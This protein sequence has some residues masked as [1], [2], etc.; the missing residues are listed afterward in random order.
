MFADSSSTPTA[1]VAETLNSVTNDAPMERLREI[2]RRHQVCCEV[3]PERS[4]LEGRRIQIGFELQLCGVNSHAAEVEGSSHPVP[5]CAQCL[6]TYQDIRQVAEWILPNKTQPTRY[7]IQA[8]DHSIH[9]APHKRKS[10]NEV[11]VTI[12]I[13]HRHDFNRA[14]DECEDRCLKEMQ[15]RL[16]DLGIVEGTWHEPQKQIAKNE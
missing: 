16:R 2:A 6:R 4:V 15:L 8:F 1:Q 11:V 10:R 9:I 3:W 12:H 14:V 13:M 7:E 5:G